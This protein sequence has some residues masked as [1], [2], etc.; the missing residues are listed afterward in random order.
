MDRSIAVNASLLE[1]GERQRIVAE[2]D[3]MT[4][5]GGPAQTLGP[6]RN[7][8]D[9]AGVTLEQSEVKLSALQ[10]AAQLHAETAAHIEPQAGPR[11]GKIRQQLGE[12][13]GGEILRNA[14]PHH[15]VTRRSRHHVARLLLER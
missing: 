12:S 1:Y 15:A 7:P 14:E 10:R 9:L 2:I 13:I 3:G 11:T 6:R 8:A 5:A 4:A